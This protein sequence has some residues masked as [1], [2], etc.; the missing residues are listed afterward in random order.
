MWRLARG[1]PWLQMPKCNSLL[2]PDKAIFAREISGSWFVSS[3]RLQEIP[4]VCLWSPPPITAQTGQPLICSLCICFCLFWMLH[5]N[6]IIQY[7]DFGIQR[8]SLSIMI[9]RFMCGMHV[10]AVC[11]LLLLNGL[12]GSWFLINGRERYF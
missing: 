11:F 12:P 1:S 9:L 6:G 2:I 5:V 8:L 4:C 10:S 7:M 3:Q